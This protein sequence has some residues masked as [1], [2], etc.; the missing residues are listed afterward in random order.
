VRFD[1]RF[2]MSNSPLESDSSDS[3]PNRKSSSL[4]FIS[5]GETDVLTPDRVQCGVFQ[6]ASSTE[7]TI[8]VPPCQPKGGEVYLYVPESSVHNSCI[9]S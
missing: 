1:Y 2:E 6:L 9:I 4:P 8:S 5:C 3:E 7:C